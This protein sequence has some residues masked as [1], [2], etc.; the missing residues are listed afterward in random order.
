MATLTQS[1]TWDDSNP[2]AK[3]TTVSNANLGIHG[4]LLGHRRPI[5]ARVRVG[6]TVN[7]YARSNGTVSANSYAALPVQDTELVNVAMVT[8]LN[9]PP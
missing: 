4:R 3:P 6:L 2:R 1:Y 5:L 7:D 8:N 9:T